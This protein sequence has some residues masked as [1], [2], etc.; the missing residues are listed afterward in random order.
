MIAVAIA[1]ARD[2]FLELISRAQSGEEVVIKRGS[3][4]VARIVPF[5]AK[6][7]QR[8]L[9]LARGQIRVS[10]DFDAP[11]PNKIIREFYK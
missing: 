6:K 7:P 10:K 11:L 3:R 5:A 2:N 4:R 9:G 8:Q 1:D